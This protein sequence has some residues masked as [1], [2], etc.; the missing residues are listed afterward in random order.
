MRVKNTTEL[1]SEIQVI[2]IR[3]IKEQKNKGGVQPSKDDY[4]SEGFFADLRENLWSH[5]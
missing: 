1:I 4:S 5:L 3:Q 2:F